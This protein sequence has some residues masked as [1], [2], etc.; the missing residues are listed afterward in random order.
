MNGWRYQMFCLSGSE[1]DLDSILSKPTAHQPGIKTIWQKQLCVNFGKVGEEW[2]M[3]TWGGDAK[4]CFVKQRNALQRPKL[5][6]VYLAFP[7]ICFS[8][9]TKSVPAWKH[10]QYWSLVAARKHRNVIRSE[11]NISTKDQSKAFM[12]MTMPDWVLISVQA[13]SNGFSHR[14][15]SGHLDSRHPP[16]TQKPVLHYLPSLPPAPQWSVTFD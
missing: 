1:L 9:T 5:R 8:H 12:A 14:R 6:P 3:K 10:A 4:T 7:N 11:K 13:W 16:P 15:L 2:C